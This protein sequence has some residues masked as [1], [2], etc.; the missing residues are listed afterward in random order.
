MKSG[1]GMAWR[2]VFGC[3]AMLVGWTVVQAQED[4]QTYIMDTVKTSAERMDSASVTNRSAWIQLKEEV[5]QHDFK[6]DTALV[7]NRLALVLR[8]NANGAEVYAAKESALLYRSLLFP[9]IGKDSA[10]PRLVSMSIVENSPAGV[11]VDAVFA[12]G[13]SK[14]TMG[15][16]LVP[17]DPIVE[18]LPGDGL[19]AVRI[20]AG[21]RY[22]VAPNFFGNDMAFSP[23][24]LPGARVTLAMEQFFLN[25]LDDGDS[26]MMCVCAGGSQQAAMLFSGEGRDRRITGSDIELP[27]KGKVW[28]AFLEDAGVWTSECATWKPPFQARWRAD[29][30]T[31]NGAAKSS[32]YVAR[33]AESVATPG[34]CCAI[35][36]ATATG[37]DAV[38]G[39]QECV[40]Y[41]LERDRTTPFTAFCVRDIMKNTLGVGPCE[42]VADKEGLNEATPASVVEWA[43][44][45]FEKK[46]DVS[47]ADEIAERLSLMQAHMKHMQ[48][49]IV[50]YREL[51]GRL[52]GIAAG[53]AGDPALSNAVGMV[54]ALVEQLDGQM[55]AEPGAMQTPDE[56]AAVA[57]ALAKKIVALI[58]KPDMAVEC[59]RIGR[60]IEAI[61][62]QQDRTLANGR[63]AAK[64]IM[65]R[66]IDFGVANP[67][68]KPLFEKVSKEVG[69]LLKK[70]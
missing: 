13:E 33:Q 37:S 36:A 63:M 41:P 66:C 7:N 11:R 17:G 49:R 18:M 55:R 47:S 20:E 39:A 27:A 40:V 1:V 23:A 21:V 14:A 50:G 53:S 69:L 31:G 56:V 52:K 22:V 38:C 64:W 5:L 58:G 26:I 68:A 15:F 34:G 60:D 32:A 28:A 2:G 62:E 3:L 12:A 46:K 42:Y 24:S 57:G 61:G 10:R 9:S 25:L 43:K 44:K 8:Q 6:G 35:G 65:A 16:R 67:A 45:L 19:S 4:P 59:G 30:L 48:E 51:A 29:I 54:L 70:G